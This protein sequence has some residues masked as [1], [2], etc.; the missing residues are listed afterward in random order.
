M[1]VV[2]RIVPPFKCNP[3]KLQHPEISSLH[4]IS[5]ILAAGNL[6]SPPQ[7]VHPRRLTINTIALLQHGI[8]KYHSGKV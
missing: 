3:D 6:R 2:K 4:H 5:I 7:W 8:G 1:I